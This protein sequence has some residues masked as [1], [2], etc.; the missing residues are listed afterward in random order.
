MKNLLLLATFFVVGAWVG[1]AH[2]ASYTVQGKVV[3]VTPNYV[4]VQIPQ[5]ER[6]C[7]DIDIPIY[8]QGSQQTGNRGTGQI[9]GAIIGGVVGNQ[10]GKGN[11]NT[12]AT[13]GGAVIGS[14]VGGNM[15]ENQHR[16]DSGGIV[17]YKRETRCNDVTSYSSEQ[18]IKDYIIEYDYNGFQGAVYTFNQYAVGDSIALQMDLRAK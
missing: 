3:S 17:G 2:A 15:A 7:E 13:A 11:G 14:I 10:I 8:S 6:I 4:T 5:T 18:R 12:A 1:G 9:L 16:H